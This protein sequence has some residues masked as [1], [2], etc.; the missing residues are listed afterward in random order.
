MDDKVA[1]VT[2]GGRAIGR[3]IA[4]ALAR[5][6]AAVAVN[7]LHA[8]RAEGV[9]AEIAAAGGRAIS[10]QGDVA[11]IESVRAMATRVSAELGPTDIL[12][13]NAGVPETFI[14]TPFLDTKP[15]HWESFLSVNLHGVL[16]CVHAFAG[17]M[18][19]RGR[20]RIVT[21]SSEAWR[22]GTPIGISL[23]AA[24]KAGAIGFTRQLAAE[25]GRHGV[26]ANCIA[27]G[28]MDNIPFPPEHW[29]RY[30][31]PRAGTPEDV[32][33][34]VLYLASDTASW[35][36]GQVIALNGGLVTS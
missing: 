30:P 10:V 18:C 36:T 20:G 22:T 34:L 13:N 15:E 6:G 26:T 2:G 3:G 23:Y 5:A 32:A 12:V 8:D 14:P 4:L 35:I 17:A 29:K 27:L 11:D 24:G 21:I 1:V 19:E 7:D 28:E 25:I 16:H 31:I 9:A 33:A